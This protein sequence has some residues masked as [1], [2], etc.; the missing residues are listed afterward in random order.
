MPVCAK[1]TGDTPATCDPD[2]T[3]KSNSEISHDLIEEMIRANSG[4]FNELQKRQYLKYGKFLIILVRKSVFFSFWWLLHAKFLKIN[5]F[6]W[7]FSLNISEMRLYPTILC[8]EK[9]IPRK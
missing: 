7:F 2:R 3:E 6:W 9:R 8:A 1:N 4:P 5:F